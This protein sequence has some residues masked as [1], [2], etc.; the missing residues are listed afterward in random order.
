MQSSKNI[1]QRYVA[2]KWISVYIHAVGLWIVH[3]MHVG[4][5]FSGH[6]YNF[7]LR[8]ATLQ[9]PLCISPYATTS[10][11]A[12]F[13]L[14]QGIWAQMTQIEIA[15]PAAFVHAEI[16]GDKGGIPYNCKQWSWSCVK[17]RG[18]RFTGCE[19]LLP[20]SPVAH[21][22]ICSAASGAGECDLI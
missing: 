10:L 21:I 1:F 13:M 4:W 14:I 22:L 18:K 2:L 19:L 5:L 8:S 12:L 7:L 3:R 11:W 6:K 20:P 15:M 17:S 16:T 9:C